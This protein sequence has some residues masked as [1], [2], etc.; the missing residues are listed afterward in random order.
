MARFDVAQVSEE[1]LGAN[2]DEEAGRIRLQ[3]STGTV[4]APAGAVIPFGI[5]MMR[6]AFSSELGSR[7][8]SSVFRRWAPTAGRRIRGSGWPATRQTALRAGR[9]DG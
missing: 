3:T 1:V 2:V 8:M 5:T 7:P 4:E 6:T 9:G